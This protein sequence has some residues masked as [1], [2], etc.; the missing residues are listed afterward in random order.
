MKEQEIIEALRR[1]NTEFRTLEKEHQ[2]LEARLSELDGRHFLTPEEE[3]EIKT[4]K[5]QKL[6]KKDKMAALIREFK[7]TGAMN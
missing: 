2:A 5:K 7:K 1:E 4:I 3:M 6:A